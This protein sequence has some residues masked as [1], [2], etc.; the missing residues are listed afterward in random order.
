MSSLYC[1]ALLFD[2]PLLITLTIFFG[3]VTRCGALTPRQPFVAPPIQNHLVCSNDYSPDRPVQEWPYAT[4]SENYVN[5]L[6]LLCAYRS[7][8]PTRTSM[9]CIC[10][11]RALGTHSCE[12]DLADPVIWHILFLR[13]WCLEHCGCGFQDQHASREDGSGDETVRAAR[14]DDTPLLEF[15]GVGDISDVESDKTQPELGSSISNRIGKSASYTRAGTQAILVNLDKGAK[16]SC[17]LDKQMGE[18]SLELREEANVRSNRMDHRRQAGRNLQM[19]PRFSTNE[20]LSSFSVMKHSAEST[21]SPPSLKETSNNS[22]GLT[23][24]VLT[25]STTRVPIQHRSLLIPPTCN[26]GSLPNE[27]IGGYITDSSSYNPSRGVS[28]GA[29]A[30]RAQISTLRNW[31]KSGRGEGGS[32]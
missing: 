22:S 27:N 4:D 7:T 23:R 26:R 18:L 14:P 25:D 6:T 20:Q 12:E 16:H 24:R 11:S 10:P 3:I 17:S 13:N 5:D 28:Y 15:Y 8:S 29:T 2:L 9:G 1:L 31:A 32:G 30:A 19:H 21:P